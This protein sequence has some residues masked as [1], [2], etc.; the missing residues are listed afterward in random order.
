MSGKAT[1][2]QKTDCGLF[3][4]IPRG[5]Q[6]IVIMVYEQTFTGFAS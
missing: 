2:F 4:L 1:G 6:D 5:F 3:T